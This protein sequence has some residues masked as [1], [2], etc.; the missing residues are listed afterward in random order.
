MGSLFV[1]R[2]RSG[3]SSSSVFTVAISRL[4]PLVNNDAG[5]PK[6]HIADADDDYVITYMMGFIFMVTQNKHHICAPNDFPEESTPNHTIRSLL[7]M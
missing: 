5:I 4:F 3:S 6:P 1:L 2:V 7:L